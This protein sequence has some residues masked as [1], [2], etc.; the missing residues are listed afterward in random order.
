[1]KTFNSFQIV[2]AFTAWPFLIAW[3]D[4]AAFRGASVAFWAAIALYVVAFFMMVG[5]VYYSL[6][7]EWL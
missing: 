7:R 5:S 1:M 6:D 3:L 4:E 2:A